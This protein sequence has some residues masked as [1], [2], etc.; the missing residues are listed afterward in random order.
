MV[1]NETQFLLALLAIFAGFAF[2]L[3]KMIDGKQDKLNTDVASAYEHLRKYTLD[4]ILAEIFGIK[5]GKYKP[6]EFF[7][8]PEVIIN[9]SEYRN[10][11]FKFNKVSEMRGSILLMLDLSFKTTVSIVLVIIAFII[12]NEIFINS[13]YNTFE[14]N[15]LQAIILDSIILAILVIFLVSFVKKFISINASFKIQITEL[16]GGLP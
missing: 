2:V 1:S 12:I 3:F 9:L 14:I 11:L 8:T 5:R 16:K 13:V 4:P 6:N 10:K 7:N 15:I